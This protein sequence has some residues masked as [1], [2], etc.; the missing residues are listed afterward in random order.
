MMLTTFPGIARHMSSTL[1][2][3][4]QSRP[5]RARCRHRWPARA[6][7]CSTEIRAARAAP[8]SRST[9]Y[10]VLEHSAAQ[11]HPP[12]PRTRATR[13][14]P[15]RP[16]RCGTAP[17]SRATALRARRDRPDAPPRSAAP[18][19]LSRPADSTPV[20]RGRSATALQQHRRFALEAVP[21]RD[22]GDRRH[23]V[24]QPAH[25][26]GARRVDSALEH[27]HQHRRSA[28][29][30]RAAPPRSQPTGAAAERQPSLHRRFAAGQ[31][32]TGAG[33]RCART[34]RRSPGRT[35]RPRSCRRCR[36]PVPSQAT[37]RY[38]S[39]DAVFGGAGGDVRLVMLHRARPA[40]RTRAPS[41]STRSRDA[42]RRP[43]TS[44]L[45]NGRGGRS[46]RWRAR[47]RPRA[48]GVSRSPMCWLR[49]T[50]RPTAIA[51]VFFRWPPT[52]STGGRSRADA[53]RQRRVAAGA[54]HHALAAAQP[55]ATTESSQGRAIGRSC[56]RNRSAIRPAARAPLVVDGDRL[57][58]QVAAGGHER[59]RRT[60]RISR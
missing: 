31:A 25:A 60:R 1:P 45:R 57:V 43:P 15:V 19:P 20:P 44:R 33:G 16:A 58:A 51:T 59:E 46:R 8:P 18:S 28:G 17:R 38:G 10:R 54:A 29:D 11:H 32:E 37:P 39:V 52:A 34:V 36:S 4:P 41:A 23:G 50:C 53:H 42:G 24:E 56:I 6:G 55:R 35:R 13:H 22:P 21:L 2:S 5:G 12:H 7:A 48:S 14:D 26:G 49:K 47:T 40:A 9:R 3:K 27:A 30:R